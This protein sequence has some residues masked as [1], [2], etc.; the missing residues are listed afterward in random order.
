[1]R[2]PPFL[3]DLEEDRSAISSGSIA[4]MSRPA[5]PCSRAALRL[6]H[7]GRELL[8]ELSDLGAVVWVVLVYRT[9]A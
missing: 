6:R 1:V 8:E 3:N 7:I 2:A 9:T 5:G 4:P